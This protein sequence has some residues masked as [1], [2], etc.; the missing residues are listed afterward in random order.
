MSG[1]S[2]AAKEKEKIR[3]EVSRLVGVP[4]LAV[5]VVGNDPASQ[6]YVRGKERDCAECGIICEVHQ[7][8]ET[9]SEK[10]V[11]DLIDTLNHRNSVSGIIVQLPLPKQINKMAVIERIHPDKDVDCFRADNVGRLMLGK[12]KFLPCTPSG[13]VDLLQDFK[14]EVDGKDCVVIGRSDIVGKPMAA[15]LTSMGGTVTTCHSRTR[16]LAFYTKH[17]DLIVCAV[18]KPYFLTADMVKDDAVIVDVG[19]NRGED[20]KL[21]GDVDFAEVSKKCSAITP[22]PGG[23]GLMTRVALL[24]NTVKAHALLIGANSTARQY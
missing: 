19:I 4:T 2:V 20:G 13:I 15:L 12:P 23:V 3:E 18:G 21:C 11:C 8:E 9:A 1:K 24:K 22:V 5:I 10:E 16:N 14:I 7:F 17:A 6:T